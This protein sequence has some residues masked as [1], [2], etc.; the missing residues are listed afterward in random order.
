MKI[1]SVL[2]QI[3]LGILNPTSPAD[4]QDPALRGQGSLWSRE[5]GSTK[6]SYIWKH[7][8]RRIRHKSRLSYRIY[9]GIIGCE[10]KLYRITAANVT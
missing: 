5:L 3:G 10:G 9:L 8:A 1:F 7:R 2:N 6:E 4:G